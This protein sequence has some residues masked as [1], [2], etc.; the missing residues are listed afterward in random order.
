MFSPTPDVVEADQKRGN[1]SMV[2]SDG[3]GG[4]FLRRGGSYKRVGRLFY[5]QGNY[6]KP[7]LQRHLLYKTIPFAIILRKRQFWS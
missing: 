4:C 7:Q 3:G 1:P 2:E 6:A 5:F